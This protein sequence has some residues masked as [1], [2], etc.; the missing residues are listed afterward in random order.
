ML[1]DIYRASVAGALAGLIS[2]VSMKGSSVVVFGS[3]LYR[4][5]SGHSAP[6]DI[7]GS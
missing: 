1:H 2:W 4:K 6:W 5:M 7:N 3:G